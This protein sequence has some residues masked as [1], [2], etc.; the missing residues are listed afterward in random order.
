MVQLEQVKANLRDMVR[1]QKLPTDRQM[2]V[3]RA[4]ALLSAATADCS[5]TQQQ[6]QQCQQCA[7]RQMIISRKQR[8]R[9]PTSLYD[10]FVSGTGC[11]SNSRYSGKML[12]HI[13]GIPFLSSNPVICRSVQFD[14]SE[15]MRRAI[16]GTSE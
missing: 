8:Y 10:Y 15:K 4:S 13:S 2:M 11:Y 9:I 1:S 14:M 6:Q 12:L 3:A 5:Q 16:Y 7:H